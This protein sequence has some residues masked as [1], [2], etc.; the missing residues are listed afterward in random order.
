LELFITGCSLLGHLL[1]RL[2][3]GRQQP[4]KLLILGSSVNLQRLQPLLK[5]ISLLLVLAL[6]PIDGGF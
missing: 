2:G 5:R 3:N 6:Q 1:I 4:L